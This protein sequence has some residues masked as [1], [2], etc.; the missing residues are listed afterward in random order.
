MSVDRALRKPGGPTPRPRGHIAPCRPGRRWRQAAKLGPVLRYDVRAGFKQIGW[1]LPVCVVVLSEPRI[2]C[3]ESFTSGGGTVE[4]QVDSLPAGLAR[5][6]VLHWA[7]E[8]ARAVTAYYE[9]FPVSHVLVRVGSSERGGNI[10]GVTYGGRLI[11]MRLGRRATPADLE[12]DW[13]LTHEMFHLAFPEMGDGHEWMNEGLS[14]Y[15]EPIAR[16]RIGN[17]PAERVWREMARDLPQ[18]L[19]E[20]GDRGLEHT[21]TWGRTYWGGCLFW[22][23]A[24]VR[25]REQ[26]DN[27]KSLDDAL[28]AILEAGGDGSRRWGVQRVIYVGDEA[29]GTH[30]LRDLYDQM[31]DHPVATDLPELWKRLGISVA[32][33]RV[34]VKGAAPLARLREGIMKRKGR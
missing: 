7:R 17:L 3:A 25:I 10:H 34:T 21:H 9:K 4:V 11:R 20:E 14:T 27:R 33:D 28:R 24:D 26:T 32:N 8:A 30:V 13:V 5:Q 6:D 18:G 15:L 23:L 19:P 29:T 31:A 2:T 1:W 12:D 16:V 22:F